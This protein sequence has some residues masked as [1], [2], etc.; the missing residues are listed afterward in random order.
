MV[1]PKMIARN[2]VSNR[3]LNKKNL[4]VDLVLLNESLMTFAKEI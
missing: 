3:S 2:N 1:I 4:N